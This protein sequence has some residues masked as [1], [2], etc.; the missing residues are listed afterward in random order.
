MNIL[1]RY[2]EVEVS[3]KMSKGNSALGD[4]VAH[5]KSWRQDDTEHIEN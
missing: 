4:G 2:Q 1:P 3:Q 5:W